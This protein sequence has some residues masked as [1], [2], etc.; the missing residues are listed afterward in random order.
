MHCIV[1]SMHLSIIDQR[2]TTTAAAA[3]AGRRGVGAG[4]PAHAD[5]AADTIIQ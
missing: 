5:E 4:E 3:T 2:I 1:Y